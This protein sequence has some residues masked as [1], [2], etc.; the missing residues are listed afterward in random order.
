MSVALRCA[1]R[2]LHSD[3]ALRGS[4]GH[5]GQSD[6]ARGGVVPRLRA[7]GPGEFYLTPLSVNSHS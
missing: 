6:T 7:L 3:K 1:P 2:R 5:G 4:Y